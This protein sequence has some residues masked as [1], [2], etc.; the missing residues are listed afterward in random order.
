MTKLR[1]GILVELFDPTA[2]ASEDAIHEVCGLISECGYEIDGVED[3]WNGT[4]VQFSSLVPTVH[5]CVHLDN[6][7]ARFH[8][9]IYEHKTVRSMV[10]SSDELFFEYI[11][12][13]M[14]PHIGNL[15]T[16]EVDVSD[17]WKKM[18]PAAQEF[19]MDAVRQY[20]SSKGTEHE[21]YVFD[22]DD[23]SSDLGTS[24]RVAAFDDVI[25][26][27]FMTLMDDTLVLSRTLA[28]DLRNHPELFDY[29]EGAPGESSKGQLN[30]D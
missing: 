14:H 3:R 23:L 25:R 11:L 6:Q 2:V 22:P 30:L 7:L 29:L 28:D 9:T 19:L 13:P 8:T 10:T 27:Q 12:K 26:Q 20:W 24:D 18:N 17:K 21:V 16:E 1:T 4:T 5:G 15:L